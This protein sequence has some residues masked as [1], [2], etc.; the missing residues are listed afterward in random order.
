MTC[1]CF[2]ND[3]ERAH[4][5][6][7][8]LASDWAWNVERLKQAK[9]A[10]YSIAEDMSKIDKRASEALVLAIVVAGPKVD[11]LADEEVTFEEIAQGFTQEDED[12][13][14]RALDRMPA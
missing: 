8:S 4:A 14:A 13:Q 10:L 1:R 3:D 11:R 2:G 9:D 6:V 12:E 5:H 7:N